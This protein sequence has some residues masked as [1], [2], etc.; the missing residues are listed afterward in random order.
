MRKEAIILLILILVMP[1]VLGKPICS[2]NSSVI[3]DQKEIKIGESKIINSLGI[4]L[5]D[6]DE[7]GALSRISANIAID[8]KSFSLKNTTSSEEIE[9]LKGK[10][11]ISLTNITA[12]SAGI[13]IDSEIKDIEEG[14]FGTIKELIVVVIDADNSANAENAAKILIGS[15]QITLSNNGKLSEK[16]VAGNT[17]YLVELTSA[18]DFQASIT[19]NKCKSGDILLSSENKVEI[20]ETQTNQTVTNSTGQATITI[21]NETNSTI[22]NQTINEEVNKSSEEI[23]FFRRI[24]NWIKNSFN[25]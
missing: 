3:W 9:L 4:G 17:T 1:L 16:V 19:V 24:I 25:K 20:N 5:I 10:Y 7:V 23:G 15:Q 6:S 22:I 14:D 11:T 2:D 12:D 8:A 21:A 18:S 13:K